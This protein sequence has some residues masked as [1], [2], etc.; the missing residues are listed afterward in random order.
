M[1][2]PVRSARLSSVRVSWVPEHV[3]PNLTELRLFAGKADDV[4]D[5]LP[6]ELC[7]PLGHE[8]PG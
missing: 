7:L 4:V 3:G 2:V 8:Q 5:G 6:D 1:F